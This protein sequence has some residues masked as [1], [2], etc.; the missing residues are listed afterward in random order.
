MKLLVIVFAL[1]AATVVTAANGGSPERHVRV[2][3][4]NVCPDA[5]KGIRFYRSMYTEHRE[6]MGLPGAVPLVDYGCG[7]TRRRAAEWRERAR[8]ARARLAE[9]RKEYAWWE[10]LP[11]NWVA[12]ARCET[13]IN[14]SHSNSSFVSAFGIRRS[15]YDSDAAY[16][17]APPWDDADPPTPREQYMAALGHYRQYGDGWGCPGP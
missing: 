3:A 7:A 16:M 1:V 9:W 13:H 10:W 14:W 2:E 5:R 6:Q 17:G 15:L 8:A 4:K 12:V 11:S